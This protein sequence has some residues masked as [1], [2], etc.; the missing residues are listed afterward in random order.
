MT[1][2]LLMNAE[3]A[4]LSRYV[5]EIIES[6]RNLNPVVIYFYHPDVAQA[7]R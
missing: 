5:A 6:L 2:L 4:V 7:L 1:D 3:P